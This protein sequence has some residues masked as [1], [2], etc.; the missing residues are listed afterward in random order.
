MHSPTK[1]NLLPVHQL[2]KSQ[3]LEAA[4]STLSDCLDERILTSMK[5]LVH[6]IIRAPHLREGREDWMQEALLHFWVAMKKNPGESFQWYLGGCRLFIRDRLKHGKSLDS[7]KRRWQGY[8]LDSLRAGYSGPEIPEFFCGVDPLEQASAL[9]DM[10]AML[11]RLNKFDRIVLNLFVEG[12]G[13][14]EVAR[15]LRVS[16]SGVGKSHE[17][18][19]FIARQIGLSP[20]SGGHVR[21]K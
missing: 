14:R 2:T 21:K 7:P 15:R 19:R 18:I 5:N 12:N 9:D 8:S 3:L 17:R 16:P 6:S 20:L 10:S 13:T 1:N 4:R 11:S